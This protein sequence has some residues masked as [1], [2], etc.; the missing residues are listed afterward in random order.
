M[1]GVAAY[2]PVFHDTPL[3]SRTLKT[4]QTRYADTAAPCYADLVLSDVVFSREYARGQ[5]LKSFFRFRDFSNHS[6]PVRRF[7]T[8]VQNKLATPREG[9]HA[10]LAVSDAELPL[11]LIANA[12]T[13]AGFLANAP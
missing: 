11:A 7:A 12:K 8:W 4:S 2:R 13:F 3:D 6:A 5:N 1:L 9:K 10:D